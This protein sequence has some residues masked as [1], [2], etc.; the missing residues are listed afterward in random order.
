MTNPLQPKVATETSRAYQFPSAPNSFVD[1]R[2]IRH[3]CP[4]GVLITSDPQL[5]KELD[6]AVDAGCVYPGILDTAQKEKAQI[7]PAPLSTTQPN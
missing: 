4:D 5:I 1:S 6:A 2:G 3:V 7:P